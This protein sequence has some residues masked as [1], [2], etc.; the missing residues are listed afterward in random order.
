M[1]KVAKFLVITGILLGV[2]AACSKNFDLPAGVR[3]DSIAPTEGPAG[4]VVQLTGSFTAETELRLCG[5][6]FEKF[7][8]GAVERVLVA[9]GLAG[10]GP[11][12]ATATAVVPPLAGGTACAITLYAGG[13]AVGTSAITFT[14]EASGDPARPEEPGDPQDPE[15][16]EE[17]GD[18]QDPEQPEEPGDPQDPEQPE[19]PSEPVIDGIRVSPATENLVLGS[20]T[21]FT[22]TNVADDSDVTAAVT[23]SSSDESVATVSNTTGLEGRVTAVG[24]GTATIRA[25]STLG[26]GTSVITVLQGLTPV[27]G[28]VVS[29]MGEAS[30]GGA[31]TSRNIAVDRNLRVHVV[32]KTGTSVRYSR[33]TDAGRSFEASRELATDVRYDEVTIAT[34]GRDQVYVAYVDG[35]GSLTVARSDD[36]GDTWLTTIVSAWIDS[37]QLGLTT[38]GDNV[39]VMATDFHGLAFFRS[40]DRGATF[41]RTVLPFVHLEYFDVLVDP[42]NGAVYA[43]GDDPTIRFTVSRDSG[44]TFSPVETVPAEYG[45][46]YSDYSIGQLGSIIVAGGINEAQ[47]SLW[48]IDTNEW[49]AVPTGG[50]TRP[51]GTSA[52]IDGA[53]VIHILNLAEPGDNRSSVILSTSTDN[54]ATYSTRQVAEGTQADIAPSPFVVGTPLIYND[55]G[56]IKYGF[57]LNDSPR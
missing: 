13:K 23:W 11:A 6:P 51:Y 21:Q 56:T 12:S 15:Q 37:Y 36:A 7:E 28:V 8:P 47:A 14:V 39:Y 2:L 19:E 25:E 31:N 22:A 27:T 4:S 32:W 57:Y 52:A 1:V 17:P 44:A 24:A 43:I 49:T 40:D 5:V 16:P 42:R 3:L 46:F 48:N 53:D 33:S 55:G 50:A 26:S 45:V 10:Y 18:P 34:G 9:P 41:S 35:T 20:F 54:G 30:I 38:F 29:D